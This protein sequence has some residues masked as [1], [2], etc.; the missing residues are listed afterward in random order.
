MGQ[1]AETIRSFSTVPFALPLRALAMCCRHPAGP[2]LQYRS[3]GKLP[4]AGSRA[5]AWLFRLLC[6]PPRAFGA[7][8]SDPHGQARKHGV[9]SWQG[10]GAVGSVLSRSGVRCDAASL[11]VH[12]QRSR[13]RARKPSGARQAVIIDH[14]TPP[15]TRA[16]SYGYLKDLE[17]LVDEYYRRRAAIRDVW[18]C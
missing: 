3:E 11:P 4:F 18:C 14:L 2:W 13:R 5:A 12:R 7:D 1:A 8:A 16:E 17:A 15:L 6:F 9:A 10:H